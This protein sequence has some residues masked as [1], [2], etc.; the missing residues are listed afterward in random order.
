V[1][2]Y[3]RAALYCK[4][5]G[6]K[7]CMIH[8]AHGNL[9][10]QFA[11]SYFNKRSDEYGGFLENRARFAREVLNAVRAAVGENFVMEYRI[12]ADELHPEQMRFPET[13]EFIK[14]IK[15]SA[16]ILHASAGIH[17]F[18]GEPCY[19]RYLLQ[20]YTMDRM[21][22][23][24]FAAEVKRTY[25]DL[26]VETV[27]SIK[28]PAMAEEIIASGKSDIVAMNR[29][30]HADPEMPRRYAEGRYALPTLLLL[31]PCKPSCIQALLRQPLWGR[32]KEY[33]EGGREE[34]GRRN[35]RRPRRRRGRKVA[36]A[37]RARRH[38]L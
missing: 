25:P 22:N 34:K 8:G 17:D 9:I 12:S 27:S 26:M 4:Q 36:F 30:L 20:N 18:W 33:P 15:D 7:I 38:A 31:P 24:H 14:Y 13:L 29:A 16:D 37:E 10:A 21:Y 11:S 1:G 32:Y 19:M 35:R 2:K 3:A 6:M 23:V 5:A 28:D